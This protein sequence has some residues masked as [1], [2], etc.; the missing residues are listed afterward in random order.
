MGV[1]SVRVSSTPCG[2]GVEL[3]RRLDGGKHCDVAA[4]EEAHLRMG[5]EEGAEQEQGVG[6]CL[7][8]FV[9]CRLCLGSGSE[10]RGRM[11]CAGL[12]HSVRYFLTAC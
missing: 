8:S 7:H 5:E 3:A 2:I 11:D 10:G 9:R 6:E 4:G 12:R 1:W